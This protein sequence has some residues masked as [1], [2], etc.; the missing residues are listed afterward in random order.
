MRKNFV[1]MSREEKRN[2]EK[3]Y[4]TIEKGRGGVGRGGGV[5][6]GRDSNT[7]L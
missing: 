3:K 4:Q 5:Y 6:S 7:A 1:K 2:I